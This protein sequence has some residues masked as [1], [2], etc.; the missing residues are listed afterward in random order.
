MFFVESDICSLQIVEMRRNKV[1]PGFRR[2]AGG[3]KLKLQATVNSRLL[4]Y[5][6]IT[7]LQM[8]STGGV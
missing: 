5:G 4:K 8:F 2:A 6:S 7:E 3:H 1:W